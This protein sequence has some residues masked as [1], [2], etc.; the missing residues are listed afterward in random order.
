[1]GEGFKRGR[2]G[3]NIQNFKVKG[4]TS[5]PEA[6][7]ENL[8][9]VNTDQK[10]TGWIFSQTEPSNPYDGLV[11][12]STG[13][14]SLAAFNALRKNTI[15]LCPISAHQYLSGAWTEKPAKCWQNGGWVD[16]SAPEYW[17]FKAGTGLQ[18][19]ITGFTNATCTADKIYCEILYVDEDDGAKQIRP[20]ETVDV[21]DYNKIVFSGVNCAFDGD[22]TPNNS[23]FCL[24]AGDV[25][26]EVANPLTTGTATLSA[27]ATVSLDISQISGEVYFGASFQSSAAYSVRF[28]NFS[29]ENIWLE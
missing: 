16:V 4:G 22:G 2:G 1:M 26:L 3:L 29:I 15:Q 24:F 11:W 28:K 7:K 23:H 20:N 21:T 12:F 13:S 17:L 10:I 14:R 27:N 25:V 18:N 8:F 19:G 6:L 5:E 9:W